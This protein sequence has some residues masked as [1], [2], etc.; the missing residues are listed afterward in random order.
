M[1][2]FFKKRR[3]KAVSSIIGGLFVLAI[4]ILGLVSVVY[5]SSLENN[6]H[7]AE[8]NV[9]QIDVARNQERL[10]ILNTLFGGTQTY[11]PSQT[12]ATTGSCVNACGVTMNV[13][14]GFSY[15]DTEW[16]ASA[17][18]CGSTNY[19]RGTLEPGYAPLNV[20]SQS[21]TGTQEMISNMNFTSNINGWVVYTTSTQF[22]GGFAAT[23]GNGVPG[24]GVGS[25]YIG[26][27]FL[28]G[29]T[30][31]GNESTR[32]YLD[33]TG[34][35][36]GTLTGAAF[37]FAE[38]FSQNAFSS[39]KLK[40]YTYNIYLVDESTGANNLILTKTVSVSSKADTQWNYNTGITTLAN[41]NPIDSVLTS[42]GYYDLVLQ[43]IITFASGNCGSSC[44][45]FFGYFDDVGLSIS[46]NSFV[47][48]W[49]Y[50][51][52]V[53]QTATSVQ[54]LSFS[55]TTSYNQTNV[56]QSIYVYDWVL[57][58][59]D[60]FSTATASTGPT[61]V[62]FTVN[63][64]NTGQFSAQNLVS[65]TGKV[66]LRIYSIRPS[67]LNTGARG[68]N[69]QV[70]VSSVNGLSMSLSYATQNSFTLVLQNG[71]PQPLHIIALVIIDSNGHTYINATGALMYNG[72]FNSTL[73]FDQVIFPLQTVNVQV[74]YRWSSGLINI[75][76]L[77]SLG[78]VFS[79]ST[80]AS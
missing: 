55:I 74:A 73:T 50:T 57:N 56:L 26:A 38:F 19:T 7:A 4:M 78:N 61:T 75:Y 51:F 62:S 28:S 66:I 2:T 14:S 79:T 68:D 69:M 63:V 39:A 37:S 20:T 71:G 67:A 53:N 15:D 8:N 3:K 42:K 49:T 30:V 58:K 9:A 40:S 45:Q 43:T 18:V 11:S 23:Q 48:D 31:S 70:S 54:E 76:L 12:Y 13:G 59:Y 27:S 17:T 65:N 24:S 16:C 80:I 72:S 77:T 64:T 41:G 25:M 5:V 29:S 44:S 33:P 46:Y 32:F 36:T 35:G 6:V 47:T 10:N 52:E 34:T 60:L 21:T 1:N 22:T